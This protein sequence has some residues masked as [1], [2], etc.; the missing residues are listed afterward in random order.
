MTALSIAEHRQLS[1]WAAESRVHPRA[2][3]PPRA[4]DPPGIPGHEPWSHQDFKRQP[5]AEPADGLRLPGPQRRSGLWQTLV[6]R[7]SA[8]GFA[9][10]PRSAGTSDGAAGTATR[11]RGHNR[12]GE[13]EPRPAR[14]G[15][16]EPWFSSP[17]H[18]RE[19]ISTAPTLALAVPGRS[20]EANRSL[21]TPDSVLYAEL[22]QD[23]LGQ[24]D[25][26]PPKSPAG[27]PRAAAVG[28]RSPC[29]TPIRCHSCLAFF[30]RR[31]SVPRGA[32]V[33]IRTPGRPA[34]SRGLSVRSE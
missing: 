17:P 25:L 33:R 21:I 29:V 14:R 23:I 19:R 24:Q 8:R 5:R 12:S 9:Q 11:R 15:V 20:T 30:G 3:A 2:C 34:K 1:S 26:Q 7:E 28:R 10:D 31:G 16:P 13:S 18:S 27:A 4:L 22:R 6:A 32:G